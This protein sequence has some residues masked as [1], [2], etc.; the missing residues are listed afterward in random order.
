M[1]YL[2]I[3]WILASGFIAWLVFK[4]LIGVLNLRANRTVDFGVWVLGVLACY[5]YFNGGVV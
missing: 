5:T 3:A 1:S 4:I 2:Q